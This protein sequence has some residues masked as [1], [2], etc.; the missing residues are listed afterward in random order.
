MKIFDGDNVHCVLDARSDITRLEIGVVV[1]D[2]H[3]E[4]HA[5]AHQFQ[6]ILNGDA[7]AGNVRLAKVD[8]RP[9]LD[10]V[11]HVH[12]NLS[13]CE[14][15]HSHDNGNIPFAGPTVYA[16]RLARPSA[17]DGPGLLNAKGTNLVRAC[18]LVHRSR[19]R[20]RQPNLPRPVDDYGDDYGLRV[21]HFVVH[22]VAHFVVYASS[23]CFVGSARAR[24]VAPGR[25]G[26]WRRSLAK[27][28]I[29]RNNLELRKSGTWMSSLS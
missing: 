21:G 5:L 1:A 17:R 2:D 4:R 25:P 19:R 8:T 15:Q 13:A 27:P 20:S 23:H 18:A 10:P 7:S 26:V 11:S 3:I 29:E 12:L 16:A 24:R 9:D 6:Y 28:E 14:T 22:F